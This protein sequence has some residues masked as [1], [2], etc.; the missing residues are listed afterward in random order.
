MPWVYCPRTPARWER[1]EAPVRQNPSWTEERRVMCESNPMAKSS[2]QTHPQRNVS[3]VSKS[4]PVRSHALSQWQQFE[5]KRRARSC[6]RDEGGM[7]RSRELT[8]RRRVC[9]LAF[10]QVRG[11][12]GRARERAK[13]P[14]AGHRVRLPPR[15]STGCCIKSSR[16]P[17]KTGFHFPTGSPVG[18]NIITIS[19]IHYAI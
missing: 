15:S 13:A 17:M 8:V 16:W 18:Q 10:G 19:E 9:A 3:A 5:L 1:T 12:A 4:A 2:G 6:V 14:T 7:T 11:G